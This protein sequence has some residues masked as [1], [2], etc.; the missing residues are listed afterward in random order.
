MHAFNLPA[1]LICVSLN[2]G[3]RPEPAT[4]QGLLAFLV[5]TVTAAAL[6]TEP[7]RS[8]S[9][10]INGKGNHLALYRLDADLKLSHQIKLKCSESE[11]RMRDVL[12]E[13]SQ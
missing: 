9:L 13:V 10:K 6:T 7:L 8:H 2:C 1:H 5:S 11:K 4:E 12:T 3:G